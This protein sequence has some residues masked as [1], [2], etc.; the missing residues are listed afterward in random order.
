MGR[1]EKRFQDYYN[2]R[3][4]EEI[5]TKHGLKCKIIDYIKYD[6]ITVEFENGI[7]I[8]NAS[9]LKFKNGDIN[10]T[11][12]KWYKE[13]ENL[14]GKTFDNLY[15]SSINHMKEKCNNKRQNE[16]YY[17]CVCSCGNNVIRSTQALKS[18]TY[19]KKCEECSKSMD[20]IYNKYPQFIKNFKYVEDSKRLTATSKEIV[21]F[22]CDKCGNEKKARV[23]TY[24][25]RNCKC[26]I[27][28]DN[29]S[30]PEKFMINF[31]KQMDIYFERERKFDWAIGKRY[32][33]YIPNLSLII[34]VHGEQHYNNKFSFGNT[35]KSLADEQLN[36]A[37]KEKLAIDNNIKN[38]VQ[39][40]CR[41]SNY[42]YIEKSIRGSLLN[43]LLNIENIDFKKCEE[44]AQS[45][46]LV[47]VCDFWKNMEIKSMSEIFSNFNYDKN[48]IQRYLKIGSELGICDYNPSLTH[49][50][51]MTN[52][53]IS[54][55]NKKAIRCEELKI[56]FDSLKNCI[57]YFENTLGYKFDRHMVSEVCQGK[58]ESYKGYTFKY[59]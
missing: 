34:E 29:I 50:L 32:D 28:S 38:Y 15:V 25:A 41:E 23:D 48:T 36:D 56:D 21:E 1:S 59:I 18:K 4:G 14:V 47:E 30:F 19:T 12:I 42:K 6:N 49:K 22:V 27:C 55:L 13:F 53:I 26:V 33:F 3:V 39:L 35:T 31:L 45:S 58:R 37:L 2:K 20:I 7:I 24:L 8:K 16:Y 54:N 46:L 40:D 52:S 44:Y 10:G 9:Y 43:D 5:I 17:N 57:E 11:G 51:Y